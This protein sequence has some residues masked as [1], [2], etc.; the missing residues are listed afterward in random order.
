MKNDQNMKRNIAYILILIAASSLISSPA[1]AGT[2]DSL[3][4]KARAGYNIGGTTPIPLPET[5]R[6]I[7]S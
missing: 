4:L 7:E 3:Q 5:I 1:E 6:S 2:L